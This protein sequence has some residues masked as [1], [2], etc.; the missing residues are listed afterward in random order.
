ML[1]LSR[2]TDYALLILT[3]LAKRS[4]AFT[5]LRKLA[6]EKHLPYRFVAQVVRPLIRRGM[7]ESR[8]G[9]HGGY[10]LAK[11]ASGITVHEV[12]AAEEGGVALARCLNPE[13]EYACPQKAACTARG[14]M[15]LL[16]R[17]ILQTLSQHTVA[18]LLAEQ[19]RAL[20]RQ[21]S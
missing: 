14:G 3:A 17:M 16:Q 11:D 7:L 9:I 18:D 5:S 10:R 19:D 15:S 13:K 20:P 2:K 1:S 21:M 8:E 6:E 12:V 4:K